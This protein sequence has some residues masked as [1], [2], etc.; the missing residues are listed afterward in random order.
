MKTLKITIII[1][2]TV[3][4]G[5]ENFAQISRQS[6]NNNS[7]SS[8]IE[9]YA[10][11]LENTTPVRQILESTEN[12]MVIRY[13]FSGFGMAS[14]RNE[15]I[16][17]Q[18]LQINEFPKMGQIG[19]P[20]LPAHNDMILV[21]GGEMQIQI[22]EA[23][24]KEYSGFNIFPSLEP[25]S[26][27]AGQP[28]PAFIMD[29]VVYST[30]AFWP[31][32][33]V[34]IETQL[35]IRGVDYAVVQIRPIQYNPV[36]KVIRVYDYIKY[37][38]VFSGSN[39]IYKNSKSTNSN[40]FLNSMQNGVL[41][42]DLIP[43]KAESTAKSSSNYDIILLT[44]PSYQA[45]AD[46]LIQWKRQLGYNVKLIAQ[47][48]WT[49]SAVMDSV[50]NIYSNQSVH[51]DYLIILGD[52]ADVPAQIITYLTTKSYYTDLYYVCMDGTGDYL[53]DMARGRISVSNP[54]EAMNTVLKIINY[55]RNPVS[56][57]SFYNSVMSCGYFQDGSTYTSYA[58]GYADRRFLHTAEEIRSYLMTKSYSVSRTYFAF[59]NRTPSNYNNGYY[60]NGQA[61]S[62]DLLKSNG[63]NW[64][65]GSSDIL[66]KINSGAFIVYHRDHG[67][68]DG[69]GWE[70][71][72]FLNQESSALVGDGNNINQLTNGNKLPVL[73]SVNC[74][75][76]DFRRSESFAENFLR[77][78]NGGAVGVFAPSYES[79]SGY[80]DALIVG[81]FDAIWSNPGLIPAFG[82]GGTVNPTLNSHGDMLAM[83]DV[84]NQ[85][86]LRMVQTWAASTKWKMENEIFHYFGDPS[87]KIWTAAPTTFAAST[88]PNSIRLD[89]VISINITNC[90]DAFY[91]LMEGD[92][93]LFSGNL[94]NGN[95]S[96]QFDLD[97]IH[98]LILTVYKHNFRPFIQK[99]Q[100][101]NLIKN[102]APIY[103]AS[104][105]RVVAENAKTT[106]MLVSWEKGDG[107]FSMLVLS[108]D[109]VFSTPIDSV[110]YL[111]DNV[112]DGE[113]EQVIFRGEGNEVLIEGLE[114][115][116]VYWFRVYE[117]N[118]DGV[119]TLYQT[120]D[121]VD[122]P[123]ASD[124]GDL[125]L[126]VEL[127]S[128]SATLINGEVVL[129]WTTASEVNNSHFL[130]EKGI[131]NLKFDN[132]GSVI[133]SGNSNILINYSFTDENIFQGVFYYR[134]TQVDFDGKKTSSNPIS[135]RVD[136]QKNMI[137]NFYVT[138]NN[139]SLNV[140][141]DENV[142]ILLVDMSGRILVQNS[143][144]NLSS[145]QSISIPLKG[146]N[147]G[148]Y[149]ISV[150]TANQIENK[151]I[152]IN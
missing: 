60:S 67:Y 142:E 127:T 20:A 77:K 152:I 91:T 64:N 86:L 144:D 76:G 143:I 43:Q 139:I 133:G 134:L 72:Y 120:I 32:N 9:A 121:E 102:S 56:D 103:Q 53:A 136:D 106:S 19:K 79:F 71:P 141:A 35:K 137:S 97:S 138:E 115:G 49:S 54:T 44:T 89:S 33:I 111:A 149:M 3:L 95:A 4:T 75:T 147:S 36:T 135:V 46:T 112:Y 110:V 39:L 59:D 18:Y 30:N 58:D 11:P 88:I 90:S 24:Y 132:I 50:H 12:T 81:M 61:I 130:V 150:K 21:P 17:Y 8:S 29:Q 107:D 101:N 131:N 66:S 126:P 96:I 125:L 92:V 118:N 13:E 98:D 40:N 25:A 5:K 94:I 34:E 2:L 83:G 52:H 113:G 38:L 87:M 100:V 22:I 27:E 78:S 145:N 42:S 99:I 23:P 80:N 65:G 45:A 104:N 68:I 119:Y 140:E 108:D 74:H 48:S 31:S 146:L 1:L 129:D 51:P 37:K 151:K 128:F 82:S 105:I 62:S 14:A 116:V 93:I 69:Y 47:S 124:G 84:L 122:N 63:F 55:E 109:G 73:F 117:Y 28:E 70:H 16:S 148:M 7:I 26:D 114:E 41:N 57:P 10:S 6:Y 15:N 123:T 85:G